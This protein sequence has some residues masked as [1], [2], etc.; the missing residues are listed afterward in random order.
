MH[1]YVAIC[2]HSS[3]HWCIDLQPRDNF[4]DIMHDALRNVYIV[5]LISCDI[6]V[7]M[8]MDGSCCI[9]HQLVCM[10]AAHRNGQG[11]QLPCDN[12][13]L[14]MTELSSLTSHALQGV[15]Q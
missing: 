9:L 5:I 11:L 3:L 8:Q 6:R 12:C 2:M 10:D 15:L 13:Y 4:I 1:I 14:V 7:H